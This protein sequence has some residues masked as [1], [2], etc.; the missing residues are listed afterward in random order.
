MEKAKDGQFYFFSI[1]KKGSP[2]LDGVVPSGTHHFELKSG[3]QDSGYAILT[4]TLKVAI[5]K[6]VDDL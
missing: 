5:K 3:V 4:L 6:P 1:G 2:L